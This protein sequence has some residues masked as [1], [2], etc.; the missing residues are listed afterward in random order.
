MRSPLQGP[1]SAI[2]T[3]INSPLLRDHL[4]EETTTEQK[5]LVPWAFS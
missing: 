3:V 4:S 2:L 1:K 5:V